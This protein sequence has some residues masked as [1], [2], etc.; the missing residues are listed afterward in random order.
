MDDEAAYMLLVTKGELSVLVAQ[1]VPDIG[2]GLLGRFFQPV[3]IHAAPEWLWPALVKAMLAG[4][5]G[6]LVERI[7]SETDA[8]ENSNSASS[9]ATHYMSRS[10]EA[11]ERFLRTVD[12]SNLVVEAP[13]ADVANLAIRPLCGVFRRHKVAAVENAPGFARPCYG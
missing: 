2:N 12:L 1:A 7:L 4:N 8:N 5:A 3:E 13:D 11:L 6:A 10:A 9:S